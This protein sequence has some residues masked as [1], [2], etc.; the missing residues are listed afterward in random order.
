MEIV[1]I[2]NVKFST[3]NTS[4]L[5]ILKI[6]YKRGC[7]VYLEMFFFFYQRYIGSITKKPDMIAECNSYR[8]QVFYLTLSVSVN[9]KFVFLF[10]FILFYFILFYFI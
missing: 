5:S 10:Y 6:E 3:L 9:L 2:M 7:R 1:N 4:F 8:L